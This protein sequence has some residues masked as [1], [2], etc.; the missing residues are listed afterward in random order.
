MIARR[1]GCRRE[2]GYWLERIEA[3][4]LLRCK[5]KMQ[6]SKA[7]HGW[8]CDDRK[9]SDHGS[10]QQQQQQQQQQEEEEEEE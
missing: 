1:H 4:E 8:V 6:T 5:Q 10:V 2:A 9:F 3:T 7:Q